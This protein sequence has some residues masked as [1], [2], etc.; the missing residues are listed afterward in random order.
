MSDVG[1]NEIPILFGDIRR[2]YCLAVIIGMRVTVDDNITTV[3]QFKLYVWQ[4][5]EVRSWMPRF[6]SS[7]NA[8]HSDPQSTHNGQGF[9]PAFFM[10]QHPTYE[11]TFNSE[12]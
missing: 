12:C 1:S 5:S 9:D 7:S 2:G 6:T 4:G 10:G 3:G 8:R 11:Q